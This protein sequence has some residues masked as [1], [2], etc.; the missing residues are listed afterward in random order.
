[1]ATMSTAMVQSWMSTFNLSR[2]NMTATTKKNYC[3]HNAAFITLK[4]R[5]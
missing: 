5:Y 3:C 2:L 1:M 4:C